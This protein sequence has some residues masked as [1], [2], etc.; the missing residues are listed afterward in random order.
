MHTR[1]PSASQAPL[2]R[3]MSQPG[4]SPNQPAWPVKHTSLQLA[5]V[6]L[7]IDAAVLSD[8]PVQH[9]WPVHTAVPVPC[10]Q[11]LLAALIKSVCPPAAVGCADNPPP[12]ELGWR[13]I[14]DRYVRPTYLPA[15]FALGALTIGLRLGAANYT[16]TDSVRGTQAQ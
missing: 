8:T 9:A 6:W 16:F 13:E 3:T 14:K 2:H 1:K 5:Q 4:W 12:Q 10:L 11:E 15:S 7:Y